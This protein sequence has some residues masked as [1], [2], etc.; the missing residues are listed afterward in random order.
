MSRDISSHL[1]EQG[2]G[3]YWGKLVNVLS[4][5]SEQLRQV[6]YRLGKWGNEKIRS[7]IILTVLSEPGK[8]WVRRTPSQKRET[9]ARR[10]GAGVKVKWVALVI[11]VWVIM[12]LCQ[13]C[14]HCGLGEKRKYPVSLT[15]WLPH[16]W[17]RSIASHL[18][19]PDRYLLGLMAIYAW[20]PFSAPTEKRGWI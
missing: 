10:E 13:T 3:C 2:G 7:L 6:S 5:R 18:S 9:F 12:K 8:K 15:T 19:L 14:R 20:L 4:H 1:L 16:W 11:R 17:P